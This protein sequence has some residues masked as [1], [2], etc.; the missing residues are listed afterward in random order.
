MGHLNDKE[1]HEIMFDGVL[2][3]RGFGLH[4]WK[5]TR[6][7]LVYFYVWRTGDNSSCNASAPFRRMGI[8]FDLKSNATANCIIK[9]LDNSGINSH[10]CFYHLFAYGPIFPEQK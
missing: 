2:L 8:P 10:E 5:I 1:M 7:P 3:R 4:V 9:H 6:A